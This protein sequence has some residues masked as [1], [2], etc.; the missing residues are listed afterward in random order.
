MKKKNVIAITMGDPAGVGPEIIL[1]S[2]LDARVWQKGIP[3][4]VGD[5]RVLKEAQE[6]LGINVEIRRF[7]NPEEAV[8]SA[9][10]VPVLDMT[11]IGDMSLLPLGQVSSMGGNAAVQ[12]VRKAVDLALGGGVQGIATAPINK[13][14]IHE[15]G[16]HYIGHTE[17][18]S[19]MA[20]R[21]KAM[22]MF[23]VDKLKIFFHTRHISLHQAIRT[24]TIS[25]VSDTIVLAEKC[26][27]AIGYEK[28]SLVLAALNPHASESGLFGVEEEKILIPACE[29]AR[30]KGV[31]VEGPFPADSVFHL[32]LEG[33]YDAV[34]SLYHDQGHI[35]AKTY[36]FYRT[37]SVTLGLPFVRTSVDHGTAFDIAWQGLASPLGMTEAIL[38]CF[39]LAEKYSPNLLSK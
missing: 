20:Q 6:R 29:V 14:A 34:I 3:I 18:L 11:M 4:V 7:S 21:E 8:G 31:H 24:L 32:A 1:K 22:T 9:R 19:E 38:E 15:A 37:V 30:K 17:M 28:S 36:D 33:K 23:M 13:A 16:F 2:F 35:A 26:L 5:Y 39:N 10:G 12:Y 25:G 27:R